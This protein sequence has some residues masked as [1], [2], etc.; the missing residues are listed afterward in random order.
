[1]MTILSSQSPTGRADDDFLSQTR[2][3]PP[4]TRWLSLGL[5]GR[6]TSFP[7]V[8]GGRGSVRN[9]QCSVLSTS[10]ERSLESSA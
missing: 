3:H 7:G 8:Q 5:I 9:S 10:A 4:P 2:W 1:M 6:A